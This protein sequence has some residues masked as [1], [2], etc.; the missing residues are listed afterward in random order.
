[1]DKKDYKLA[2]EYILNLLELGGDMK[3]PLTI[4]SMNIF[5]ELVDK[6]IPKKAIPKKPIRHL[7][8]FYRYKNCDELGTL[9]T[10][11]ILKLLS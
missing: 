10:N 5:K 6:A 11:T 2:Y 4:D 3:W 9:I 7:N 1:M 8:S